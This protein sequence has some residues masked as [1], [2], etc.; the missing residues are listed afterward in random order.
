MQY[1]KLGKTD[2]SVSTICMGCWSIVSKDFN[3]GSNDL[4]DSMAAIGASLDAGV[5]FFDTAEGYGGGESETILARALAGRRK[6]V[7]IASKVSPDNLREKDLRR[8]C[9]DSLRRL[10][11]DYID[12]YQIHWPSRDVP[13]SQVMPVL[14][15][16]RQEGKIRAIGVSN[17]SPPY[18]A[19]ATAAGRVET[20]QVPYSLLWRPIEVEIQPA[21]IEH[22]IGILCYSPLCQGLLTG[23]FSKADEVP[24]ERARLRLFSSKRKYADH[25]EAGAEEETFLAI[26]QIRKICREIGRPMNHVALAWLLAQPAVTSVMAG[27]RNAAQ[28]ADNAAAADLSL[29]ADIISRLSA[30]TES[31]KRAMGSN[32]D[33]WQHESRLEKPSR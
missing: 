2:I 15:S 10:Q 29:P 3:W 17:F 20:N 18:L 23:K 11:S 1:R 30:A 5:N 12:L 21:C 28:A 22:E 26:D 27:G 32:A 16:L 31:V 24:A 4:K 13:L 6:D 19:E 8:H 7:V 25:G 14:E 33:P 9:E